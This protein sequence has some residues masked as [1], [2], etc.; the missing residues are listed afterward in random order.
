MKNKNFKSKC[1]VKILC[2]NNYFKL[3]EMFI[4]MLVSVV[5]V[6][7]VSGAEIFQFFVKDSD[8]FILKLTIFFVVMFLCVFKILNINNKCE[9]TVKVYNLNRKYANY[10][11]LSK[12][13]IKLFL[14]N[15]CYFLMSAAMFSGLKNL[16]YKLFNHNYFI[17]FIVCVLIVFLLLVFGLNGVAKFDIFVLVFVVFLT[18][19]LAGKIEAG[20]LCCDDI[21]FSNFGS[22]IFLSVSYVFM[23]VLQV[24]PVVDEFGLCLKRKCK[25]VFSFLFSLVCLVLILIFSLFL[26]TR[27][28]IFGTMP[29]LNYFSRVGGF[30]YFLFVFLLFGALISSLLGSLLGLKRWVKRKIE[31]DFWSA[32]IVVFVSF[33]FGLFE[34]EFFVAVV[35]P[36]VGV[37]NFVILL[38]L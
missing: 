2:F 27:N 36:L 28:E 16:N 5:G 26:K 33:V 29:L 38:F 13:Q 11:L 37:I 8:F 9:K 34:F 10:T 4:L 32:V 22:A 25:V 15:L 35:Y 31:G 30:V 6:G 1:N 3:F 12:S 14:T 18:I 20:V 24:Q 23:N 17:W 7:F 19:F 21:G